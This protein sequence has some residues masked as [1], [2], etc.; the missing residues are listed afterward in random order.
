M[1]G[2]SFASLR[3]RRHLALYVH[4][5]VLQRT[6]ADQDDGIQRRG[7][8]ER[9]AFGGHSRLRV[10]RWYAFEGNLAPDCSGRRRIDLERHD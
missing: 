10:P 1:K 5:G 4:E 9:R 6:V 3:P 7:F 8:V 2:V